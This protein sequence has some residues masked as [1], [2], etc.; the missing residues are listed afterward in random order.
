MAYGYRYINK[1]TQFGLTTF[2]LI[3][4]DIDNYEEVTYRIEKSFKT[5]VELIDDEFLY[6]EAKKEI[7]RIKQ[8]PLAEPMLETEKIYG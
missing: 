4:E 3:L 1:I 2:T 6:Q 7:L 8:E 5:P